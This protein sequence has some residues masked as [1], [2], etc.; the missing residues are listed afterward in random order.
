MAKYKVG[1]E[2]KFPEKKPTGPKTVHF[3]QRFYVHTD[4]KTGCSGPQRLYFSKN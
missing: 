3:T 4:S 1:G 2:K